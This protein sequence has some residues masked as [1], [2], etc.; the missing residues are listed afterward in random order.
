M[1][2]QIVVDVI[3][4]LKCLEYLHESDEPVIHPSIKPFVV[5]YFYDILIYNKS[6]EDQLV[7]LRKVIDVLNENQLCINLKKC[8]FYIY[9]LL[10]LGFMVGDDGVYREDRGYLGSAN[11]KISV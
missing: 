7:Q 10:F 11:T 6:N 4:A 1:T 5:V 8:I 2:L 3:R 9:K